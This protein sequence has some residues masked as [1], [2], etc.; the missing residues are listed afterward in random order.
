MLFE[1]QR[2]LVCFFLHLALSSTVCMFESLV[3]QMLQFVV[4]MYGLGTAAKASTIYIE[5]K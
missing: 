4:A 5:N 2:L 3:L 1:F